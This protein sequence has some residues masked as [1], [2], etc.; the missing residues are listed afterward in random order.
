MCGI[1]GILKFDRGPVDS[2]LLEDMIGQVRYRG[3]DEQGVFTGE[4]PSKSGEFVA[5]LQHR[6]GAPSDTIDLAMWAD[7][8]PPPPF[9]L[10]G[11]FGWVPTIELTVQC[12]KKPAPGPVIGRLTSRHLT[13]GIIE[14]DSDLWDSDGQLIGLARQTMKVKLPS[15]P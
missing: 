7:I 14:S 8:M 10:F 4:P 15:N 3:P 5:W 2:A 6:D 12:R 9:T 13:N 11:P 1:A